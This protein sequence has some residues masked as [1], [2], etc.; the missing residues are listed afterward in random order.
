MKTSLPILV[1]IVC[2]A[3]HATSCRSA[4][5]VPLTEA[6]ASSMLANY[7]K[8]TMTSQGFGLYDLDLV[9]V[10]PPTIDGDTARVEFRTRKT[11]RTGF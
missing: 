1:I 10:N 2:L 7:V 4:Y 3:L 8:T 5:K 11:L 6:E 9:K